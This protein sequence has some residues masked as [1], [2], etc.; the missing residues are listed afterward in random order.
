MK[1]AF[2]SMLLIFQ[3]ALFAQIMQTPLEKTN[4][5]KITS[6]DV[7]SDFVMK[8]DQSSDL[9]S[10]ETIG[11]SVE[12]RNIYA[13]KFSNAVF[14]ED[15]SKI[16]VLFFAQQHG[17]EQSGKEGAL[18]LA[19]SLLKTENARLFDKIDL[20]IV[21]L[22]NP[23][24]SEVNQRRNKN[25]MDL[26]RNHLI[27]TEPE[28]QAIHQLFDQY[29]FEVTMDVHEYYPWDENWIKH[30]YR[31]NSEI[32]VGTTTNINIS[33]KIR[34]ISN[35]KILPYMLKYLSDRQFSSFEY[36][37]G[38]P[39]DVNY[40]RHSTYD[41]NDGRQSLGIQNTLSFIQEGMN[42]EDNFADNLGRRAKGQM[43]GMMALLEYIFQ[44]KNELKKAVISDR[45]KLEKSAGK[46]V[47]IQLEH[48]KNGD[49]L[50]LP[51][52]AY[53]SG[54]DS[55]ITVNDYHPVVK[56]ITVVNK[57][58]GYLIPKNATDLVYWAERHNL[59]LS[60]YQ[61]SG[62]EKIC[63]Y[64]VSKVDSID[65]E[66]DIVVD[67][68][69]EKKVVTDKIDP[70]DFFYLP[71]SHIK[72]NMVVTALEPKS[73]LGLVTYPQFGHYLKSGEYFRVLCVEK[74]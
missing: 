36:C 16:R 9:L 47:A 53:R 54:N 4:F 43:T 74:E 19:A 34:D 31:K 69:V 17:N 22:V 26:N 23:D 42:G 50:H 25:N 33:P 48:V 13:L 12:G 57:P 1:N 18:L 24:G 61:K 11:K 60:S 28:T 37:P 10:V 27:L 20:V 55:V 41:I 65:F 32:T 67:P 35:K 49:K 45:K 68:V 58:K 51:V 52:Y 64:F 14:G 56:P 72:G 63:Q 8:L 71:T 3:T 21:P 62:S 7:L 5:T 30:G 39:P 44:H 38:G 29:L 66:G 40:I 2:L 59:K 70:E 46:P 6:Y 15:K 73:E